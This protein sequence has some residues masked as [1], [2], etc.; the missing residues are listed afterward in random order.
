MDYWCALWFWPITRAETL[1][2]R[3]EFLNEIS[4][5]LR[6]S[7]LQPGL[8]PNQTEDLFGQE[9][10]EHATEIANRITNEVGILDFD[11]LFEQFPRLKFVDD[12]ASRRH[13]HHWELVFADVFYG[14]RTDGDQRGGFDLVL[15]NPPW[16]K[17]EWKEA[18]VLGEFDPSLALRR[19]SAVELTHGWDAALE[20]HDGLRDAWIAD[21]EDSEA[22]QAY[23]KAK[24]NYPTLTGQKAN[25]FKAFL[26]QAWMINSDFGVSGFLHPEGVYDDPRGGVFRRDLYSRL[27]AHFQ[28]LNE[29]RIFAEVDHHTAFSVNIYGNNKSRPRFDHIANLYAPATIDITFTHDGKGPVPGLKDQDGA[30]NSS[31][32]RSRALEIDDEALGTFAALYDGKDTPSNEARLPALHARELLSA[33]RKLAEYPHRVSDLQGSFLATQHWNETI[34]QQ[35]GT[36]RRE[37]RFPANLGEMVVSGPHFSVGNPLYKTPRERCTKSSDY[38]CLDLTTLPDDYLPRTNYVPACDNDEYARR[39]PKVPWMDDGET[40]PK[41]VT[42]FYRVANREMV[43]SFLSRTLSTAIISKDVATIH[44]VVA[45]AFRNPVH[46]VDFF[47]IS[48]SIVIDF[49]VKS[50]GSGHVNA[51]LLNRLPM[52][53]DDCPPSIRNALRLRSLCLSCLTTV[54][55]DLWE[56]IC[57]TPLPEDPTRRHF[58]AF[59]ADAWTSSDPRLRANFF[60]DLTPTWNRNVALRTDYA[61]RQAMIEIDVLVAK[62][63]NLTL[64]E[65]LTIYRVQFP[66]LRQYEADTY[67]D[68][69]GRIV[70]TVSKGLP[71]VGLPRKAIRGD[72]SYT[73]DA[74]TTMATNSTLLGWEDIRDL[75]EGTV[76]RRVIDNTQP[77]GPIHREIAYVAPFTGCDREQD[78]RTVWRVF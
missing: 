50:T 32:H 42:D 31:G 53:T 34:S 56:E 29:R 77:G 35:N 36:I 73:I 74:P 7:V 44:T 11:K 57:K 23:L 37:T 10:A 1:P 40:E 71:G 6:G 12:M 61:R 16:I 4:L 76:R 55:A 47:A 75:K 59:K 38:D 24:Q 51:S 52:I 22:T 68:A 30:W 58:D 69:N 54:Y 8:G 33:V 60:T 20:Q 66:V 48:A 70:F 65:L 64:D 13:F 43:N 28:F 26:P 15:G 49:F 19:Q 9:Y 17:V 67:Y 3:D 14:K 2:T 78:Y 21:V 5:V 27:R 25:L 41:N 63:L 45:T 72:N 39:T 18:G 46:C 62:A